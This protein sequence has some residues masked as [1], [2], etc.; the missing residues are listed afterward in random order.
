MRAGFNPPRPDDP[1]YCCGSSPCWSPRVPS[2]RSR[3]SSA[4]RSVCSS[5]RPPVRS[6]TSSSPWVMVSSALSRNLLQKESSF[7]HRSQVPSNP[8]SLS[9]E[10]GGGGFE[11]AGSLHHSPRSWPGRCGD[12]RFLRTGRDRSCP[13]GTVASRCRADPARTRLAVPVRP[14]AD[15]SGAPVLGDQRP[16]GWPVTARP[17]QASS[18]TAGFLSVTCDPGTAH[19]NLYIHRRCSSRGSRR[20]RIRAALQETVAAAGGDA[21]PDLPAGRDFRMGEGFPQSRL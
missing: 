11:P 6:S 15:A 7:N 1:N 4:A 21:S 10:G 18:R 14:V 19:A 9:R 8:R 20:S 17:I 5:T 13:A 3:T 16:I 2:P 12:L